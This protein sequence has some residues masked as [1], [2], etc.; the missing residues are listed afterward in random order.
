MACNVLV[1]IKHHGYFYYFVLNIG[2]YFFIL[3]LWVSSLRIRIKNR[4]KWSYLWL[5]YFALLYISKSI[6]I[7]QIN[8][9][10]KIV[11]DRRL[12]TKDI[13]KNLL[14]GAI[15]NIPRSK[16]IIKTVCAFM[17]ANIRNYLIDLLRVE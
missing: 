13:R 6:S 15:I 14:L 3:L 12:Y 9:Y 17:H 8:T 2:R 1:S 11:T 10:N 4:G 7:H 16:T 5:D